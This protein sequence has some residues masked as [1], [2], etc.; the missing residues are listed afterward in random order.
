MTEVMISVDVCLSVCLGA[1]DRSIRPV[2]S[3]IEMP[4]ATD[5]K[6]DL[7]VSWDCPYMTP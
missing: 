5:S 3:I 7:H 1:V 2:F 4:N 6:F